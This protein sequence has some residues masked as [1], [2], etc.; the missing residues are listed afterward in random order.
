MSDLSNLLGD[1][2]GDHP[3]DAAP[4]R[5]E[6]A[7][8]E[9][10]P[11]WSSESQLD[12]AFDGWVPG[13]P[14]TSAGSDLTDALAA[15]LAPSAPAPEPVPMPTL[16]QALSEAPVAPRSAWTASSAPAPAPA[17]APMTVS[18]PAASGFWSPGDDDIFPMAKGSKKKK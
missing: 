17:P 13:E 11:E 15:A 7:A 2:Y 5:R 9:R 16:A 10:A 1:V 6:P 14:P 4:V 12:R 8:H 18:A 3:P